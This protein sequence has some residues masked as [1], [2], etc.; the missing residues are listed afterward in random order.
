MTLAERRG[1]LV[2]AWF[3]GQAHDR[4]G[5]GSSREVEVGESGALVEA[6]SWLD[7]YFAGEDPG[8][9]PHLSPT[10]TTFQQTVWRELAGI[11]YGQTTTYGAIARHMGETSNR[12]VSACA[13]GVAVGRNPLPVFLPCHRVIGADGNLTGYAGGLERK[14]AL[15]DLEGSNAVGPFSY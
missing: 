9:A 13:V 12:A 3:D 5:L 8:A 4:A 6:A 10:G 15:L 11:P 7:R 1:A 14:R 2:G